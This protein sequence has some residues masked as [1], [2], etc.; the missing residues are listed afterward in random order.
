MLV[1]LSSHLLLIGEFQS[2]T[3]LNKSFYSSIHEASYF[4]HECLYMKAPFSDPQNRLWPPYCMLVCC[5]DKLY[6]QIDS[7]GVTC[8]RFVCFSVLEEEDVW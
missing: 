3:C 5:N 6:C 1:L 4:R 2:T 8:G 7:K